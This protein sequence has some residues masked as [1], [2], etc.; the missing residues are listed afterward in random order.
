MRRHSDSFASVFSSSYINQS[1]YWLTWLPLR[2]FLVIFDLIQLLKLALVSLRR[3][4]F[5]YTPR[6]IRD[7][8]KPPYFDYHVVS[9][10][11][12]FIAA[13]GL[14]YA[15]IGP[16]V[17]IGATLV[18]WFSLVV[19]KYQLLYV[20]VS[21]AESGGRMW[22]VYCNRLLWGVLLMQLLMVLTTGLIRDHWLDAVAAAPPV[23]ILAVFKVYMANT[24]ERKFT[25]YQ[26][27]PEEVQAS[28]SPS[29]DL[30]DKKGKLADIEKSFLHPALLQDKLYKIMVHKS[31]E[32]LAREV[33]SAYPWF[34][35]KHQ[36]D[37]VEIRA[38]RE[39]NLEYDPARDGPVE[40]RAV[41]W[42]ARSIATTLDLDSAT[43]A[44][45]S[46]YAMSSQPSFNKGFN[47]STD[48][49]LADPAPQGVMGSYNNSA[50]RLSE[51]GPLL[52]PWERQ[53]AGV[54]YPPSA[55]RVGP[56]AY[57]GSA[58]QYT[59]EPQGYENQQM[60]GRPRNGSQGS[61]LDQYGQPAVGG[62]GGGRPRNNSQGS[63]NMLEQYGSMPQRSR[64]N[65]QGSVNLLDHHA[66]RP[67][68]GSQ[69]SMDQFYSQPVRR[70]ESGGGGGGYSQQQW[71]GGA[72][73]GRQ[74]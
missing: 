11:I 70:Q 12:L 20:Y 30:L 27:T 49:L 21:R 43:N 40:E 32:A 64:N 51:D 45:P 55:S 41:D 3:V 17:T 60:Y 73:G 66:P 42:D 1:T 56:S 5:S 19:Y 39:E 54:P 33:L 15:P 26:P 23:L 9:V 35:G 46:V 58:P 10:N 16:L 38:V 59:A 13:V 57:S 2:G 65:S 14:V 25:Y 6:D 44:A 48:E 7:L 72:G 71:Q 74:Y 18:F 67:R 4:M 50:V 22:N 69:G 29:M 8:T 62:G 36:H 34:A 68:N 53:N 52:D 31:Q 47:R 63:V 37:G 61:L 24:I 28:R